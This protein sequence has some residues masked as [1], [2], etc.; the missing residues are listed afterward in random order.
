M[1]VDEPGKARK[2]YKQLYKN[3]EKGDG[4]VD[5]GFYMM[6]E[7][8]ARKEMEYAS[9]KINK[10]IVNRCVSITRFSKNTIVYHDR[11]AYGGDGWIGSIGKK[12]YKAKISE[13][14]SIKDGSNSP[15]KEINRSVKWLKEQ[16][17]E[18]YF[19]VD[20]FLSEK[21]GKVSEIVVPYIP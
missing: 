17:S 3:L 2:T 10:I 16:A 18:P 1:L 15:D 19:G 7:N 9:S 13:N 21:D 6:M 8:Y 5:V 11:Y 12:V 4:G 14:V 20:A